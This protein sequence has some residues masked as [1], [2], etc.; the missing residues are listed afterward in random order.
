MPVESQYSDLP[1]KK[2]H[3]NSARN[4]DVLRPVIKFSSE[5]FIL[6]GIYPVCVYRTS[7]LPEPGPNVRERVLAFPGK[8]SRKTVPQSDGNLPSVY[9]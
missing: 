3:I 4:V 8:R 6:P 5:P 9:I 2:L 1:L 7:R